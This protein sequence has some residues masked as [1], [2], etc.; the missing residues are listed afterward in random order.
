MRFFLEMLSNWLNLRSLHPELPRDFQ[1]FYD[2]E[3]YRNS[4]EYTRVRTRFDIVESIISLVLL[5]LFWFGGG[6]SALDHWILTRGF[7]EIVSGIFYIAVLGFATAIINLP[8]H[9]YSTFVIEERFGFNRTTPWLF[10]KDRLKGLALT[11]LLGGPLL[12]LVLWFFQSAGPLAWLWCWLG[13]TILSLILQFV[14]PVWILPLFNKFT[15]LEEGELKQ[16]IRNFADSVDFQFKE[17][18]IMD[19]SKRTSKTNAFFTGF[20]RN[21]RI[22][23]F[24][25]L[26][27]DHTVPEVVAV[28]AHEIGHYKKK[29]VI[30]MTIFSILHTGILFYLLSIF[31]SE[32]RLFE[33]FGMDHTSVAAGLVFFGMLYEPVSFLLSIA[34]NGLSRR[35]ELEAD[36]YAVEKGN[37]REHL[38]S[39]LKKLSVKNLSNLTPNRLHVLL[40]YTHPPLRERLARLG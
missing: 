7:S 9:L 3:K 28:L 13:V 33:A 32:P 16:A 36:R 39:S 37:N 34:L 23:L 8:F 21:K 27:A 22:A 2:A 18:S 38:A 4:Q 26:I 25:T 5:L 17:I 14:A 31:L 29:H 40:H 12:Y 30:Y 20:G 19:A 6:F 10:V 15:P 24:D 35:H 11:I 1:D